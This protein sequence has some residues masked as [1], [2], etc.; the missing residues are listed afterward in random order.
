[1]SSADGE[2]YRIKWETL[3]FIN[4]FIVIFIV[5]MVITVL[6]IFLLSIIFKN[7]TQRP[8]SC[9]VDNL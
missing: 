5:S 9:I 7:R 1:M 8:D 2:Q 4:V 3:N 6:S